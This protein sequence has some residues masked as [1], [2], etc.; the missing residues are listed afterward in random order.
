M[1]EKK[2]VGNSIDEQ[3]Q[4]DDEYEVTC[5]DEVPYTAVAVLHGGRSLTCVAKDKILR[6]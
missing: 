1:F 2:I 4:K 6:I 5:D 3:S